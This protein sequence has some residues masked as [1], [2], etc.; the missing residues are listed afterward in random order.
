MHQYDVSHISL[1]ESIQVLTSAAVVFQGVV[2]SVDDNE[3]TCVTLLVKPD[4]SA[5]IGADHI[6][7]IVRRYK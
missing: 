3:G 6:V 2:T 7:A 5:T 4:D 1:G